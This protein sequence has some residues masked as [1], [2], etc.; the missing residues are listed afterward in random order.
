MARPAPATVASP[1][2]TGHA[3]TSGAPPTA[4]RADVYA[5]TAKNA[6]APRFTSPVR[7]H[8]TFRP[9]V[10]S[11]RTPTRVAMAMRY[12]ITRARSRSRAGKAG[13]PHQQYRENDREA[14]RRLVGWRDH[15]HPD[16]LHDADDQGSAERP[17]RR[18]DAPQNGGREDRDDE[19]TTHHW[20]DTGVETEEHASAAGEPAAAQ[21][22][23]RDHALGRYALDRCQQRVVGA[24]T[25]RDAEPGPEKKRLGERHQHD[26]DAEDEE[27]LAPDQKPGN[28]RG[29]RHRHIVTPKVVAPDE[30]HD[31]LQHER[32][33]DR[34]D[35]QRERTPIAHRSE[36]DPVHQQGD[37]AG[38]DERAEPGHLDRRAHAVVQHQRDVGTDREVR[39]DG[40]VRKAQQ[41]P[42]ERER[43]RGER[44]DAARHDAVEDV[45]RDGR[46]PRADRQGLMI[47]TRSD[48]PFRTCCTLKGAERMSPI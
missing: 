29:A 37:G 48:L 33:A 14:D 19:A 5:P 18:A 21:G 45:L 20:I 32:D 8:W 27:L 3:T 17:R 39:A 35:G 43:D 15:E 34:R 30:A 16:L 4:S 12:A 2:A 44:E 46:H 40:E 31:V 9:S 23:D 42:E 47:I 26:R 11:A 22:G 7:P 36:R 1:T 41:P 6:T 24:R 10:S 13:R 28:A 25:H 38:H